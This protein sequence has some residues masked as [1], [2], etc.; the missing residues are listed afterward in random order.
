MSINVLRMTSNLFKLLGDVGILNIILLLKNQEKSFQVIQ[1]DLNITQSHLS[2]LMKK[3]IDSNIVIVRRD[4]RKKIY[5]I[6]NHGIFKI[7]KET[8]IFLT[9]LQ[10]EKIE[11]LKDFS[12]FEL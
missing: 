1:D 8:K 3:L 11:D 9:E 10:K 12:L 4:Q 2:H 6:K 5:S 7:L